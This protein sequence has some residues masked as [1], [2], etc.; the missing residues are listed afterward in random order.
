[1]NNI[2]IET[3]IVSYN[4]LSI[5]DFAY[6]TDED[7]ELLSMK[8]KIF[9][10]MNNLPSDLILLA[11]TVPPNWYKEKIEEFIKEQQCV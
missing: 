2:A 9:F 7:R 8:R 4:P 10:K 6:S 5:I 3:Y 11:Y 1:M